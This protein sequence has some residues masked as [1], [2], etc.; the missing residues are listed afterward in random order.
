MRLRILTIALL[1]A[2]CGG[3]EDAAVREL[4]AAA[5]GKNVVMVL[6]DAAAVA[7]FGYEG[8][9][10]NTTPNIDA[11]AAESV[12]FDE[13]Y[14]PSASTAHSVFGLL[15]SMHSFLRETVGGANA[16]EDPFRVTE[17]TELM[18]ELLA[19]RFTHRTGISGNSWFGPD[20][21][22]DRGFTHF[23]GAWDSLRVPDPTQPAGGRVLDLFLEDLDL[24][25]E[26][27]AFSY[28]HFLE[29]HTPYTP[30]GDFPH[31]FHPTAADIVD[32]SSRALLRWKFVA[33]S[34]ERQE[35][36]RALY[37]ANLAYVDSLVGEVVGAL[38]A[39]GEWEDTIFILSADHGEA[40][41]Q[42]GIYG[43][44]RHVYDPF[45]KIP[46]L[47]RIPGVPG[48]AGRHVEPPVSLKD[49][50]PTYL[51]L[52]SL[53]IPPQLE[54]ESLLPLIT[55]D[56][57]GFDDRLVFMR[58]THGDNNELGVRYRQYKWIYRLESN[59]YELYDLRADPHERND[60]SGGPVSRELVEV[61]KQIALW[62][63]RGVGVIEKIDDLDP[64]T[65][66]RL[67]AIGYF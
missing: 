65:R 21:G 30:P 2:S 37:D 45:V 17:V 16:H 48:L 11:L 31:R 22:L 55:G 32:A 24:W 47:L 61:R 5:T 66:A 51:D 54:G 63:A 15:T 6:L 14:A 52:L 18:P 33:P 4:R 39:R 19:P 59:S 38:K 50:L 41:W 10:R 57:T 9:A 67:R 43:H 49:L 44:G 3:D 56:R 34:P 1:L 60:L 40:F 62:F 36:I 27:P 64:E 12:I 13:A 7:H 28:V 26:G 58:G 53:E 42:H 35:M 25:G 29:P 20:F 8:Y 46:L 23:V